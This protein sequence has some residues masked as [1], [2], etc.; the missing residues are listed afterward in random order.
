MLGSSGVF[1]LGLGVRLISRVSWNFTRRPVAVGLGWS[2]F[3]VLGER[4]GD[5]V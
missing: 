1:G 3:V 4:E 5:A 2:L